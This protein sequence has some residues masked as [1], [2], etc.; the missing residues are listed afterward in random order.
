MNAPSVVD[1]FAKWSSC[2]K[3]RG[4]SYAKPMDAGDDSRFSDPYNVTD[5]EIATAK[6]DV[7]SNCQ[8]LWMGAAPTHWW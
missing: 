5:E 7:S 4:Y 3:A 6:A 2:M 1:A 8:D